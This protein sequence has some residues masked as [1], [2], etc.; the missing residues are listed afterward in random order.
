LPVSVDVIADEVLEVRGEQV[1]ATRYRL[2][3]KNLELDIWYSNDLEWIALESTVRD[4]RKL[5][6]ELT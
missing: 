4:G 2:L 1:P 5:R 3:A 6:Y